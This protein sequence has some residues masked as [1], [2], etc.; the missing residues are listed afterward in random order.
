MSIQDVFYLLGSI[1][2][3]LGIIVTIMIGVV[4]IMVYKQVKDLKQT[5]ADKV[6]AVTQT[7]KAELLSMVGAGVGRF[8]LNRLK[9]TFK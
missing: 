2:M 5:V 3:L 4:V 9:N 7:S 8:F 6:V 1:Y